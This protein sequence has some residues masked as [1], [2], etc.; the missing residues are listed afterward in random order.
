MVLADRYYS[1]YWLIAAL[2]AKGVDCVFQQ[3]ALRKSDFTEGIALG[4]RDHLIILKKPKL[5]PEWMERKVYES[6]ADEIKVREVKVKGKVLITTFLNPKEV[7]KKE[8][9]EF[10]EKRWLVEVDLMAIKTVLQMDILR[11]KTPEMVNKEI[12]VHLLGYN[13]IRTVMAQSA[14]QWQI[15]PRE[16]SFKATIQLLN[17]FRENGLLASTKQSGRI[18]RNLFKAI[19]QHRVMDRLGRVEPRVVKRRPKQYSLM[20]QPRAILR[21]RLLETA[22]LE[23]LN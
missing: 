13:L 16:I 6:I 3:H 10:Y 1:N 21:Q 15:L 7:S 23:S 4:V 2:I 18:Y 20:M 17:A 19:V 14:H 8:I 9:G 5:C 22:K 12:A 11:C